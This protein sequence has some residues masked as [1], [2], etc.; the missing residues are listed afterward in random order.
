MTGV[1]GFQY[2]MQNV[3]ACLGRVIHAQHLQVAGVFLETGRQATAGEPEIQDGSHALAASAAVLVPFC[4][5]QADAQV[6][7]GGRPFRYG[8]DFLE[9][10]ETSAVMDD[11]KR[12]AAEQPVGHRVRGPAHLQVGVGVRAGDQ[13]GRK[14]ALQQ[15]QAGGQ[16]GGMAV[17]PIVS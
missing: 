3:D 5:A 2:L 6:L 12:G 15:H 13:A 8:T 10:V 16:C 11:L 1:C 9:A 7:Q 4:A 14:T 17:F